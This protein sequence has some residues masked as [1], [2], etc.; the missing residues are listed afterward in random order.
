M[1]VDRSCVVWEKVSHNTIYKKTK[2]RKGEKKKIS[3]VTIGN[4]NFGNLEQIKVDLECRY[5]PLLDQ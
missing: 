3:L 5:S 2:K 4:G 1:T